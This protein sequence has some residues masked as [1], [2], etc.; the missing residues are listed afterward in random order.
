MLQSDSVKGLIHTAVQYMT[1]KQKC[2]TSRQAPFIQVKMVLL[3][4]TKP[5][6]INYSPAYKSLGTKL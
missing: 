1:N 2:V 3:Q 4:D 6:T 5:K